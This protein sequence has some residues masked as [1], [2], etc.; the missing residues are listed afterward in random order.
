M[1]IVDVEL[2]GA[3]AAEGLAQRLADGIGAALESP[4]G[5]LWVRVH[6][7]PAA[8]YAENGGGAPLPVFVTILASTLPEGEALEDRVARVTAAVAGLTD[9]SSDL[10]HVLFEPS[11][12][13]RMAFGGRLVR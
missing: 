9:R 6:T 12:R 3:P 8:R 5:K 10:V 13:G 7:L 2:V 11:A 4:P 1:P